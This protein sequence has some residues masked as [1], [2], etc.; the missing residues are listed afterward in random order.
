MMKSNKTLPLLV[1]FIPKRFRLNNSIAPSK[2]CITYG[3]GSGIYHN[4]KPM[5]EKMRYSHTPT[6]LECRNQETGPTP[7]PSCP[8]EIR[9]C[10]LSVPYGMG[11]GVRWLG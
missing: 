8:H 7:V 1:S 3:F 10:I 6:L 5:V 11:S 2:G 9:S 4:H